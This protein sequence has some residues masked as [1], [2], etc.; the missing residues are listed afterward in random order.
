MSLQD[1]RTQMRRRDLAIDDKAEIERMLEKAPYGFLATSHEGQPFLRPSLFWYD[2]V[3]RRIYLH[4]ARQGRTPSNLESNPR[5][6]YGVASMGR[7]LPADEAI[8]FSAEY[9]SVIAFGSARL[10]T[11]PEESRRAL[12]GLIQKYFP[13]LQP[14][15]DYRPITQSELDQTAVY[16]IEVESWSGKRNQALV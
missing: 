13:D 4:G 3:S 10:V 8:E 12:E 9:E 11:D 6:C 16:A 2:A 5:V 7:L 15:T 14:G 1:E